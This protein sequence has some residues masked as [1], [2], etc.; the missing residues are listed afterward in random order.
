MLSC[1]R[2]K[3]LLQRK[4]AYINCAYMAPLMKKVENAGKKGIKMKR[5]PYKVTPEDFFRDSE[6]LRMLFAKLIH[7]EDA[8]RCVIIPSV[9]YG[10]ANVV[11]NLPRKGKIV[12]AEGQFPSNVYPWLSLE[13][14]GY[15]VQVVEAPAKAVKGKEWNARILKALTPD[16]VMLAIG[17]VHWADGT[18]F[19]L[20][21]FRK[22]LDELDALLV[23]DG[24]QSVGA[25]P[26][27]VQDIRPDALVCAGYKWLMGPYSIGMAY[28]GPRFDGG[29]P[30]EE[31]WINRLHSEN[32]AGLVNYQPDY[33]PGALR[34]EVGEH[35]NFILVPMLIAA[36]KQ[37]LQWT[38]EAVQEYCERLFAPVMEEIKELGYGVEDEAYRSRHLFGL[39]LPAGTDA[40]KALSVFKQKR[41]S[42]SLRGE[43]TVRLAPHVY[44]DETD[45]RKLMSALRLIAGKT[46]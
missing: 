14:D 6:T 8:H 23:V 32:F 30:I 2:E 42:V 38:P 37:L 29:R 12:V 31:N 34:Y 4:Y 3:F 33:Q 36:I 44:N 5:K 39:Q 1:Q 43:S 13:K 15:T 26:F 20:K 35:S 45:I 9:S 11:A 17:H 46:D 41:V 24:T 7:A 22:K 25:L 18:L 40:A 27:S 28:Y 16:T 10:M 19:D 21:K